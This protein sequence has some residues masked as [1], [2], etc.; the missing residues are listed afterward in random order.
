MPASKPKDILNIVLLGHGGAGKTTLVKCLLHTAGVTSRFGSVNDGTTAMDFTDIE[1]ERKHSVDPALA[2]FRSGSNW[3]AIT[4]FG[5]TRDHS[6]KAH[7]IPTQAMLAT[8][9]AKT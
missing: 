7:A 3:P 4:L 6:E 9:I 2:Y 1:K 5:A 8:A